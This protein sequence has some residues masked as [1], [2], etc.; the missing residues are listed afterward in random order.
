MAK[1]ERRRDKFDP[2]RFLTARGPGQ[3]RLQ[4]APVEVIWSQGALGDAVFYIEKGWVKISVV[5]PSGKEALVALPGAGD[6]V[7]TRCLI[8]RH[9]RIASATAVSECSL[10][11]ITRA[12]VIRLLRQEPDFAEMFTTYLVREGL[13]DQK[14]LAEQLTSSSERRLALLL[15]RLAN[16]AGS[17]KTQYILA[18]VNQADLAS[19]IG[20]TRS[21]V[22]YFMNKFRRQGFIEYDRLGYVGVR[23]PLLRILQ[24][25]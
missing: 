22:N 14:C 3:S 7:G 21:R 20:T 23:N 5:S 11:R 13:R 16:N 1:Q 2:R 10:V 15:L 8:E 25:E 6:F 24:Q 12:A 9:R 19:M 4:L 17:E 18:R